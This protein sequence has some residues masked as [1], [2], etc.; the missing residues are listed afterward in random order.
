MSGV[1]ATLYEIEDELIVALDTLEM[2][3]DEEPELKIELEEQIARLIAAEITKV[4]GVSRMLT[5]FENQAQLAA[6]EIKRL[7]GRKHAFERSYERLESYAKLAMEVAGK[8]KL[9][10]ATS[11]LALRKSP[12]SVFIH[13][14]DEVPAEYLTVKIDHCVDKEKVKRD[15]KAGVEVPGAELVDDR[16]YLVR[17]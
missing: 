9:E 10:G 14:F 3:P 15:L 8:T 6:Q 5:H 2:I 13:N 17:R 7:Q 12:M 11:T 1:P 16:F 4:D